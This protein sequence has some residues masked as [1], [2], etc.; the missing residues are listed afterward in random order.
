VDE[1]FD[2]LLA[3]LAQRQ[4]G[5]VTRK[6]LLPLGVD[7][8][9]ID[10][11]I[12]VGRLIPVYVGIY[13]V[14]HV[15]T[16]PQDR[17][18]GALLACGP[19]AVLSHATAAA[20]WGVFK[21]WDVPFDVTA[22]S[23]HRRPGIRVHRAALV[24]RD[25]RVQLGLRVT[26]PARTMLDIAPR[27]ADKALSRAVNDLRRAG[28]LR[29]PALADVLE[30]FPR[31]PGARRLVPFLEGPAGPTRSG[32]E[33]VFVGF[34]ERFGLPQPLVNTTVAGFEV[35]AFFPEYG[36]IVELDGWDFHKSRESFMSDRDRD[37]TL[38][39]LGFK[40]VRITWERLRDHPEKEARRLHAILA[41]LRAAG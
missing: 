3:A 31:A 21:R 30:R 12:E 14:G 2:R 25:V 10:Y 39:A 34:C 35:D 15:P 19:Q 7:R 33:D 26:S 1:P 22:P 28:Q 18:F 27:M 38:L 9:A 8:H 37:A 23:A 4:R 17:A 5:Y 6:Q 13:A 11:R 29:L 40:T 36:L 16:L 41:R 32:F 20:A 24:R